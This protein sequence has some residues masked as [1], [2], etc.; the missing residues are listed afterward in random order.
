[1]ALSS[2]LLG[3]LLAVVQKNLKRLLAYSTIS[4]M[5]YGLFGLLSAS[6]AGYAASVFY[7]L[8]YALMSVASLGFLVIL[9]RSTIE[10][11]NIKDLAGLNQRNP[12]LA[13]MMMIV[14]LSMA[15]IPPTVCFFA[16]FVVLKA[17]VETNMT[18]VAILGL[19]FA[20]IGAYYYL[21]IIKVMYFDE[22]KDSNPIR[23]DRS[24][25]ALFSANALSILYF[26]LMPSG[27]IS[28]C[29]NVFAA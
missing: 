24:T 28:I 26:G 23:L 2:A 15:G 11:E 22:A 6:T 4:H 14:L 1:M 19:L 7:V 13:L 18:W 21:N 25:T 9:S 8:V 27:L 10:I 5:G 29:L 17:L 16:K 12:W 3:N 20:V